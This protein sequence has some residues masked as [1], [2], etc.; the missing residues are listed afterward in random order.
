M[1]IFRPALISDVPAIY[2]IIHAYAQK[3]LLLPR[4]LSELYVDFH[5]FSV[6][7][8]QGH[9]VGVGALHLITDELAEV[10]SLAV[11]CDAM[12]KG[13]GS[14]IVKRLLKSA[15]EQ[16]VKIV[17]ALTHKPLFFQKQAGFVAIDKR[18]LP[19]SL[20]GKCVK[21]NKD[22]LC[23]ESAVI[24]I[25]P[26]KTKTQFVMPPHLSKSGVHYADHC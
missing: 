3:K 5:Q 26:H 18:A 16:G 6:A 25:L 10:R 4:S 11:S 2:E 20:W 17:F 14:G 19:K 7:L 13:I 9:L 1:L 24:R 15:S 21:C 23:D 22:H 8:E 12:S